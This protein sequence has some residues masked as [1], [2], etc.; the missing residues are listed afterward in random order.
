MIAR[1]IVA[2]AVALASVAPARAAHAGDAAPP[3]P[4]VVRV[5]DEVCLVY[6]A[7]DGTPMAR[8]RP[9]DGT[10]AQAAPPR[11]ATLAMKRAKTWSS[12]P[13]PPEAPLFAAP[14]P[15]RIEPFLFWAGTV[16]LTAGGGAMA[17]D[18]FGAC[19]GLGCSGFGVGM[20]LLSASA[21]LF[22]IDALDRASWEVEATGVHL[23]GTASAVASLRG[24]RQLDHGLFLAGVGLLDAGLVGS[25]AGTLA[26]MGCTL[27]GADC[28]VVRAGAFTGIALVVAGTAVLL[29]DAL[30]RLSWD[31]GPTGIVVSRER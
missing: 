27:Q 5:G 14:R 21:L 30:L 8:C 2:F 19:G 24:Y 13:M 3:A 18:L 7:S 4:R 17:P 6:V 10:W 15:L 26:T 22:T 9:K 23:T 11:K 1:A 16:T 12:M 20:L 25:I 29:A 28:P 31:I